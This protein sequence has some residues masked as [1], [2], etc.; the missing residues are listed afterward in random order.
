[1]SRFSAR[2]RRKAVEPGHEHVADHQIGADPKAQLERPLTVVRFANLGSRRAQHATDEPSHRG[3]VI[4]D[5]HLATLERLT[6][7]LPTVSHRALP[8]QR[9]L[10][11]PGANGRAPSGPVRRNAPCPRS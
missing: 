5:D 4:G 9:A 7:L 8:T 3:I 6:S 11:P 2:H 10:A 1:M